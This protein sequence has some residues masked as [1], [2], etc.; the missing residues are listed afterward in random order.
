MAE[1]S[2]EEFMRLQRD[3]EERL[4]KM[5]Q[6]SREAVM[7]PAP[8]FVEIRERAEVKEEKPQEKPRVYQKNNGG[9][10]LLRMLNIKDM[11]LDSD[12]ILIIAVL[13]LLLGDSNDELLMLALIY[14]ML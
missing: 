1:M 9:F 10:N 12:R 2:R 8:D 11:Q 14:I 4:R 7:P 6:R 13:L 5:Q 3:A